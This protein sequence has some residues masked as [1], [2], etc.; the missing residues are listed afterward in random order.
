MRSSSNRSETA[1]AILAVAAV[2]IGAVPTF[3][4]ATPG[5]TAAPPSCAEPITACGCVID[6]PGIH[7][8]GDDLSAS[9]T[10]QP[11]CIEIAVP[12]VI[13]NLEGARVMGN[14]SGIGI[15]I[16]RAATSAIVE[17]G[18]EADSNPPQ[19]PSGSGSTA[20]VRQAEAVVSQ[21]NIGIEDDAD[22]AVIELF[23]AIGGVALLPS[24]HTP[25]N[26]TG[27]VFLN[28]VK[29]SLVGDFRANFNGTYGVRLA[30][31]AETIVANVTA[32]DNGETGVRLEASNGNRIGPATAAHNSKLGVWLLTSS[33]NIVHDSPGATQNGAA[34]ILMGCSPDR[35][36]CEGNEQSNRNLVINSGAPGNQKAGIVVRRHSEHNRVTVNHND[37]N[38]G[39]KMD[40]VDENQKCDSNIWYNNTGSGNQ[41]C[42]H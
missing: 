23:D 39:Q 17:G 22:D 14:N 21:W 25:G 20:A 1:R 30:N 33:N 40:M 15:L 36:N 34:G 16:D 6:Q 26:I 10:T 24:G 8:V 13:L 31:S 42:I 29:H 9:Q 11:N 5:Q 4:L 32:Q 19:D 41:S 37:G 27:G 3:A 12:H 35:K 38:A 7:T 18:N 2:L 28:G